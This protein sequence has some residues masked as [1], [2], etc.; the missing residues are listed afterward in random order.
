MNSLFEN[1]YRWPSWHWWKYAFNPVNNWRALHWYYQR[2]TRGWADCD[3]WGLDSYICAVLIPALEHLRKTKHGVPMPDDAVFDPNTGD[4]TAEE[5]A[6]W[7]EV[8]NIRLDEM[9]AGFRAADA[10]ING[11]DHVDYLNDN[12]VFDMEKWKIWHKEQER[13][14][15]VGFTVFTKHFLSL[16]D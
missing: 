8:W 2:A 11:S 6:R 14:R 15:Q 4:A 7:G 16:W 3:V 13:I 5:F 9:I 10:L 12:G 1:P